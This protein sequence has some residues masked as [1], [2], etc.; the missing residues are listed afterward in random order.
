[1]IR[2]ADSLPLAAVSIA[3]CWWCAQTYHLREIEAGD[4]IQVQRE[5]KRGKDTV[6]QGHPERRARNGLCA[7]RPSSER[8]ERISAQEV[9]SHPNKYRVSSSADLSQASPNTCA[10]WK[11]VSAV[12]GFMGIQVQVHGWS[13]NLRMQF[14]V[15]GAVANFYSDGL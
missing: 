10:C 1:M 2:A 12:H 7:P 3:L 13:K 5:E 8:L 4:A 14:L 11:L 15:T 6:T 9:M